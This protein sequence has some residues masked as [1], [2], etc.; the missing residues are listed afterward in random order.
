MCCTPFTALHAHTPTVFKRAE[1]VWIYDEH[2][3]RYL[4]GVSGLWSASLGYSEERL[5]QAATRQLRALPYAHMF[6]SLSHDP[7]IA[8][9]AKLMELAPVPDVQSI[10]REFG[11]LRRVDSAVKMIWY[12][13]NVRKR[14]QKKKIIAR[15]DAYHGSLIASASLTGLPSNH[16][17]FD[18]PLPNILHVA[19][20][21]YYRGARPGESE[22][23]FRPALGKGTGDTHPSRRP[24]NR[25]R[26]LCRTHHGRRRCH[27]AAGRVFRSDPTSADPIRRAHGG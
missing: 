19:K 12:Y 24:R 1:G 26:I 5:V 7:G 11:G 4:E 16:K 13:N 21:H 6:T 25:G 18:L 20:P 3:N 9:A 23:D 15:H 14:P 22:P 27:R 2:G 8:L 10:L 17:L